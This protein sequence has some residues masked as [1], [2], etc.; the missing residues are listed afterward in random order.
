[1]FQ[2]EQLVVAGTDIGIFNKTLQEQANSNDLLQINS[3]DK[4]RFVQN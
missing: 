4:I 1:M 2:H 3:T